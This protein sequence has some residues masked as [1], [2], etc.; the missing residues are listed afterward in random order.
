MFSPSLSYK[1][2][3]TSSSTAPLKVMV[4]LELSE[5]L[6]IVTIF[7]PST[8]SFLHFSSFFIDTVSLLLLS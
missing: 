6:L 1:V 4:T 3:K 2:H 5:S 7:A 8:S